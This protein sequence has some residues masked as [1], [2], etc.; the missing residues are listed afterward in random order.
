MLI[1]NICHYPELKNKDIVLIYKRKT[2]IR[3]S[4]SPTFPFK[5]NA[6][7]LSQFIEHSTA[8]R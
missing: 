2:V 8:S 6:M 5:S 7:K 1:G 4:T 3:I